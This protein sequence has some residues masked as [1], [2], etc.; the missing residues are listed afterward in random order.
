MATAA[1]QLGSALRDLLD[2]AV[3][4]D[5]TGVGES[6]DGLLEDVTR[7]VRSLT[8]R[9]S[10]HR[11]E[12]MPWP[13]ASSMHRAHR[14]F[15]PVIGTAN[16]IAP[17]LLVTP[18]PEGVEIGARAVVGDVTMRPIYEGPPGAIHG[19]WVAAL[20]DQLLGHANAISGVGGMTIEL[21]VRYLRRTPYDVPLRLR[22]R[23]DSVDG[24]RVR[25]SGEIVADG[26]VTAEASGVFLQPTA[27]RIEQMRKLAQGDSR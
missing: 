25:A 12:T 18:D 7:Q 11:R 8:S 3:L 23:T 15:S 2:A 9:L 20:L 27:E 19:G 14:P 17:P 24:R 22:A 6:A 5:A 4:F 16:P 10:E 26:V 1:G 21:T 13:E